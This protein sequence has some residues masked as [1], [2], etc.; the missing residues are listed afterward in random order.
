[1]QHVS[2]ELRSLHNALE[3]DYDPLNLSTNA[4]RSIEFAR[5]QEELQKYADLLQQI[6]I[7]RLVKQVTYS[8]L[9]GPQVSYYISDSNYF[10][11]RWLKSIRQSSWE[12]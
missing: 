4:H 8:S 10:F 12:G 9:V 1:M 3:V 7:V 11:H 5:Q 2:P 6:A